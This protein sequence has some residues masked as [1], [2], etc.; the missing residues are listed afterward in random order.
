MLNI[1]LIGKLLSKK[2]YHN[3]KNVHFEKKYPKIEKLKKKI[4]LFDH[5]AFKIE[6]CSAKMFVKAI[7]KNLNTSDVIVY[8]RFIY[9]EIK[10]HAM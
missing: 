1:E 6:T 5:F 2:K 7:L 8:V 10:K 4:P 3:L 9:F